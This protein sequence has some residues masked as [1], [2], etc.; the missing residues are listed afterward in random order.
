SLE[1]EKAQMIAR[2]MSLQDQAD[3]VNEEIYK[4]CCGV[5]TLNVRIEA[6]KTEMR[7]AALKPAPP[8]GKSHPPGVGK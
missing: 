1:S 7:K 4:T 3:S 8:N 6:L 5:E 2:Y